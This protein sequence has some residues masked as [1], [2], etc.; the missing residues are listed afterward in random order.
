MN[1]TRTNARL[2]PVEATVERLE[3]YLRDQGIEQPEGEKYLVLDAHCRPER[4]CTQ[5]RTGRCARCRVALSTKSKSARTWIEGLIPRR[6]AVAN[7]NDCTI[8]DAS[9]A[10]VRNEAGVALNRAC[11]ILGVLPKK[12]VSQAVDVQVQRIPCAAGMKNEACPPEHLHSTLGSGSQRF[13]RA[14]QR[15]WRAGSAPRSPSRAPPRSRHLPAPSR[16]APTRGTSR[17]APC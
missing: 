8:L 13:P 10:L 7:E 11:F 2:R 12:H 16:R 5:S 6:L 17:R 15:R 3:P 4:V 14:T 1:Q 9:L